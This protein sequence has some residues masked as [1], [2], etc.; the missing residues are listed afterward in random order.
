[1]TINWGH[2][3]RVRNAQ[4]TQMTTGVIPFVSE[5]LR[6]TQMTTGVIPF[7]PEMLSW[8]TQMTAGVIPFVS[9]M[10]RACR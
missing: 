6:V 1:M 5:M 10:I 3:L 4:G 2:S 8:V 9:E 7:M